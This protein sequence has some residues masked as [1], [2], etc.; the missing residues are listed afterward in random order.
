MNGALNGVEKVLLGYYTGYAGGPGRFNPV[1]VGYTYTRDE[2]R[3]RLGS[4]LANLN[5][6]ISRQKGVL[7][8]TMI[9]QPAKLRA[10]LRELAVIQR[11]RRARLTKI[12]MGGPFE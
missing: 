9:D 8:R 1:Q 3:K 7:K 12:F 6:A 5:R 4:A 10:G 2:R 11:K